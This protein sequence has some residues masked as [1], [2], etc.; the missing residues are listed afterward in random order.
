MAA[1]FSLVSDVM[2]VKNCEILEETQTLVV[3][4][5]C[6]VCSDI[7]EFSTFEKNFAA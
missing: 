2:F 4:S 6:S 3:H 5:L 1:C 7:V